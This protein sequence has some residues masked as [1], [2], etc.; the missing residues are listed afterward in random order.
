MVFLSFLDIYDS[1]RVSDN[2]P[3]NDI[4]IYHLDFFRERVGSWC[5]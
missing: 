5:I 1:E 3:A 4:N 2:I